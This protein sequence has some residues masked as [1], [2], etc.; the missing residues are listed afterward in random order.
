MEDR[1]GM[2]MVLGTGTGIGIGIGIG[3]VGWGG[4]WRIWRGIL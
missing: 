3:E 4:V 2:E 1:I